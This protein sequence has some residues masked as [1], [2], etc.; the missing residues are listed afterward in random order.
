METIT[1]YPNCQEINQRRQYYRKA[2][3]REQ[4][5]VTLMLIGTILIGAIMFNLFANF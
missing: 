3:V 5:T 1:N 4:F 2:K